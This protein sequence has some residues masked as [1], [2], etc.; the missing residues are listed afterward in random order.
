MDVLRR[1]LAVIAAVWLTISAASAAEKIPSISTY[2]EQCMTLEAGGDYAGAE[3]IYTQAL[4]DYPT[5]TAF[6]VG[7]GETYLHLGVPKKAAIDFN[8][9]LALDD[10]CGMAVLGQAT[11]YA[12]AGQMRQ[13]GQKFAE[14]H[15][16]LGE[17]P[18]FYLRRGQYYYQGMADFPHA[19]ADL[20]KAIA[21]ASDE[22]KPYIYVRK[23]SMGYAYVT[24]YDK[25]H[26]DA[27]RE[28]ALWL[29]QQEK[30]PAELKAKVHVLLADLYKNVYKD[31][32]EGFRETEKA[33]PLAGDNA[34]LQA[35]IFQV[36]Y[37]LLHHLNMTRAEH[38]A[39]QAS[40]RRS[41]K[42]GSG[43]EYH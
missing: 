20:D 32:R 26:A 9:A 38:K 11:M 22:Q 34:A 37:E 16:I 17:S 40:L 13:A 14:A 19:L 42:L 8:R 5:Y 12:L 6:L 24:K 18:D 30:V 35:E 10:R 36:Q 21:A 29:L 7:R 27:V 2:Q 4:V 43:E 41:G 1:F 25:S 33:L 3:K 15:K 23:L 39:L 28:A 31:Y